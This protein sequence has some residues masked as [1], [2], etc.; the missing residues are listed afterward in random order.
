MDL[1]LDFT[2]VSEVA[3]PTRVEEAQLG[4]IARRVLESE[5][6]GGLWEVT[7][8][9]VDDARLQALHRDYMGTDSPTDIMTFPLD[10]GPAA[11]HG[12]DLVI[13]VDQAFAQAEDLGTTPEAEIEFL[14]VHGLLHLVGWRDETDAERQA[15]LERQRELQRQ[16]R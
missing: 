1:D 6:A 5:S 15:M 7:V 8:A 10:E 11:V 13:S 4:Q 12:G 9:L 16:V 3:L 2:L 14:V